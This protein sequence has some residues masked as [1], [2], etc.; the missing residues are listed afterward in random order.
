MI[1]AS[2]MNCHM[3]DYLERKSRRK[4]FDHL[5]IH[6]KSRATESVGDNTSKKVLQRTNI[7]H[8]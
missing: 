2:G 5:E 3:E 8:I 1:E 6:E 7:A 4:G